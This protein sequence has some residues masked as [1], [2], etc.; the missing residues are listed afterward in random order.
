MVGNFGTIG[1]WIIMS[2]N[3]RKGYIAVWIGKFNSQKEFQSYITREHRYDK[4][5]DSRFEKDFGLR[6]YDRDLVESVFKNSGLN[7]IR[8]LF[9]GSSYLNEFLETLNDS[10]QQDLNVIIRIYDFKYENKI[11]SAKHKKNTLMFYENIEYKK[12]IDLSWMGIY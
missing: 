5:F 12:K 2:A 7:T 8:E 11:K 1:R 4:T 3:N 9:K 10:E 6:Y